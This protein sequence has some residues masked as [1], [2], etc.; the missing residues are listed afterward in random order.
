MWLKNHIGLISHQQ[1][2]FFSIKISLL[3]NYT[4]YIFPKISGPSHLIY[5]ITPS[6]PKTDKILTIRKYSSLDI[7]NISPYAEIKTFKK[8][9]F[10]N[11]WCILD[12]K[13]FYPKVWMICTAQWGLVWLVF[14]VVVIAVHLKKNQFISD[15]FYTCCTSLIFF[16]LNELIE[17]NNFLC[18]HQKCLDH[19]LSCQ[20]SDKATYKIFF[21]NEQKWENAKIYY[22]WTLWKVS[23]EY[24]HHTNI[25]QHVLFWIKS[26]PGKAG[27]K[28][29]SG[30]GHGLTSI[31]LTKA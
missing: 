16:I 24:Q 30:C 1:L 17:K 28:V 9:L 26:Y 5:L 12:F 29:S 31:K 10:F 23:A 7:P 27:R 20:V 6:L 11:Q 22:K 15:M 14:F 4:I 2:L 21:F 18:S 3:F 25:L 13:S 8:S 19:H